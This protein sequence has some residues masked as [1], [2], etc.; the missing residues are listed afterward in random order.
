MAPAGVIDAL[1]LPARREATE[2]PEARGLRR[3]EVRLLVSHVDTDSVAH[4]RF[5]E[6][7]QWLAP[8][9]LLVVNTSG[10]LKA[11]LT[12]RTRDDDRFELHLST[13]L[14]GNFWV[15]E[16][17][18]PGPVASL[19][20]RDMRAGTLFELEGGGRMTLLAPYPLVGGLEAQSRLWMAAL[21]LAEPVLSY[22]ERFGNPIRYNYVP[23]P[24]PESMYQ[25]VFATE[26]GS[27]EMPSAARPFTP[28]LVTRLVARGIQV[29]PLLL[30]TGVA[31]LEDHEPPYEE[32]YRV[33]PET[34]DCVNA[35]KSAGHRVVAVGTT[36]VR[37]LETVTDIRGRVSP[38][39]GW[40]N[41][42]IGPGR[43]LRSVNGMITGFH[44]PQATHLAMVEQV[45]VAAGGRSLFHLLRAYRE[46]QEAGYL[47]HEF[48]DSHLIIG[49]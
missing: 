32:F 5:R 14:P 10:T 21:D 9:D 25:T 44:E 6:L 29:A 20:C 17:R 28:E 43:P 4:S 42:V 35:A 3:D 37:A 33:P 48:G 18:R 47:W 27:A 13:R 46:A 2:P 16:V 39:E 15:I 41:L 38:G 30:H 31:S 49:G 7:P 22:L 19:P 1:T 36:V 34:A 11:A 40:T 26:P 24:W 45:I 8:G 23:L 12:G